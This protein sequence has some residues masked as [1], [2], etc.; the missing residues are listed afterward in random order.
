M[1]P[2][3]KHWTSVDR[4]TGRILNVVDDRGHDDATRRLIRRDVFFWRCVA[5]WLLFALSGWYATHI[6]TAQFP[7]AI[8]MYRAAVALPC[9]IEVNRFVG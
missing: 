7:T 2:A 4:E 9:L 1:T 8:R 6:G 5:R 3:T